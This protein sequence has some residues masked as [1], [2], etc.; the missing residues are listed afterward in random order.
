M[1]GAQSLVQPQNSG[2]DVTQHCTLQI[3]HWEGI[4]SACAI[5]PRAGALLGLCL[6]QE[7]WNPE[8]EPC[9]LHLC[10]VSVSDTLHPFTLL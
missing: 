4:T 2:A 9:A 10:R 5:I 8:L 3:A 7:S 1:Q 6:P